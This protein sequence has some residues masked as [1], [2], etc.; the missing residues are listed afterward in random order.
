MV[1]VLFNI[2]GGHLLAANYQVG[3][4]RTYT[5]LQDVA[6]LLGPGDIVEVDGN[7]TY[8]GNVIFENAGTAAQ[9]IEVR[10]IPVNGKYP[11]LSGGT[12]TVSFATPWPYTGP[13]ADHYVLD[14]FEVTGGSS[15]CIYH[16]A[17]DLTIRN[18]MVHDCPAHGIL[19]ADQGSGSLRMEHVEVHHCGNG[20]GQHQIYMATDEVHYPGSVFRLQFCYIHDGNGGNNVKSRAERNEIY[21]NWIEG[22]YYHELEL[23]GPDPWGAPDGWSPGL[24][25]E[26]SDVVGNVLRKTN[27]RSFI[28]RVGGDGTGESDGRYRFVNNTIIAN[29]NAVFRIFDGIQSIEMHNNVFYRETGGANMVRSV[30]AQW[31]TG[32]ELIAGSHNWIVQGTYNIPTQWIGTIT[33]TSPGFKDFAMLDLQP[34]SGSELINHANPSPA[35]SPGFEFPGPLF[36]PTLHPPQRMVEMPGSA[37]LRP[38]DAQLDIGAYENSPAMVVGDLNADSSV[39]I[40]D[41]IIAL[42]ILVGLSSSELRQDYAASGADVDGDDRVGLA[43][44]IHGLQTAAGV[45]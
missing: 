41:S 22:A 23:I 1:M 12:N 19:G 9:K 5:T 27:D 13:G 7:H 10:G 24:K 17:N 3:P 36:P 34:G 45:R 16:Q 11:V 14:G 31:E 2:Y 37:V 29:D 28:T 35:G 26:D 43:E 25:R 21:Y 30:E 44:V 32:N 20:S 42:R 38:D 8:P 33:G 18:T 6:A 4:G 39:D 15:R 40:T